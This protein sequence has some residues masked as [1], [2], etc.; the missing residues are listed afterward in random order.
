MLSGWGKGPLRTVTRMSRL[1]CGVKSAIIEEGRG[2]GL[3]KHLAGL[4]GLGQDV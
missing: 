3:R 2:K 4:V 1:H